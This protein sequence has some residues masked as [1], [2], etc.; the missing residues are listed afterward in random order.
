M[1]VVF[2]PEHAP[3]A[4]LQRNLQ[5]SHHET[6]KE[7]CVL[8]LVP[9]NWSEL[10]LHRWTAF[11]I[12]DRAFILFSIFKKLEFTHVGLDTVNTLTKCSEFHICFLYFAQYHY[13]ADFMKMHLMYKVEDGYFFSFLNV[14][15]LFWKLTVKI[16]DISFFYQK[17]SRVLSNFGQLLRYNINY[18]K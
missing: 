5:F 6:S 8:H 16:F 11:M 18:I 7:V 4:S 13:G 3:G 2:S 9:Q 1:N 10:P 17:L 14:L 15:K 12:F